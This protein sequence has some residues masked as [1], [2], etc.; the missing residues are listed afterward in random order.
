MPGLHVPYD[1]LINS[2]LDFS[3]G[4]ALRLHAHKDKSKQASKTRLILTAIVREFL[5]AEQEEKVYTF[6]GLAAAH[7]RANQFIPLKLFER[8]LDSFEIKADRRSN[9]QR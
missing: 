9:C 3:G 4:G 5:Q 1:S 8:S 6:G 2:G 7:L